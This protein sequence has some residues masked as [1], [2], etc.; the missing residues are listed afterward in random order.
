[1]LLPP[2]VAVAIPLSVVKSS[3]TVSDGSGGLPTAIF[4]LNDWGLLELDELNNTTSDIRPCIVALHSFKPTWMKEPAQ[5][6]FATIYDFSNRNLLVYRM[7][8]PSSQSSTC[9]RKSENIEAGHSGKATATS[10]MVSHCPLIRLSTK[11]IPCAALPWA[12]RSLT[13]SGRVLGLMPDERAF[14]CFSLFTDGEQP[15][16]SLQLDDDIPGG[17]SIATVE[18]WSSAIAVGMPGR[19]RVFNLDWHVAHTVKN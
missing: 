7:R 10:A 1:M 4:S 3:L 18:P 13:N 14:R 6:L 12:P 15:Q 8:L 11:V 5:E 19:L 17:M 9:D 2:F 16:S